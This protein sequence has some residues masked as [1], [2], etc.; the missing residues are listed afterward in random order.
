MKNGF[1]VFKI[2]L[3]V[4]GVFLLLGVVVVLVYVVNW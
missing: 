2:L 4:V 1:S 3:V